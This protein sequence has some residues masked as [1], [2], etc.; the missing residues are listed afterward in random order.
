MKKRGVSESHARGV[1]ILTIILL[2]IQ[3]LIFEAT[4]IFKK[5]Q[6]ES[7]SNAEKIAIKSI[8][9]ESDFDPNILDLEGYKKLGFS[10]AQSKS[11]LKYREKIGG[12]KS[13]SDFK[14]LYVVSPQKY[15]QLESRIKIESKIAVKP[16]KLVSQKRD[17]AKSRVV[18][19]SVSIYKKESSPIFKKN[20]T[21]D[22][23]D[24]D[25]S[26]LVLLPGIG[27][28]F[29]RK[30]ISYRERLGGFATISQLEEIEGIDAERYK[31][32]EHKVETDTSK[33][34]KIDLTTVD[35]KLLGRHPYIGLYTARAIIN[36][37]N[38]FGAGM[39][40]LQNLIEGKLLKIEY[41][42]LLRYY[43]IPL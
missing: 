3:L 14:K 35:E 5:G 25:S 22:L 20:Y 37:R 23:N 29:A 34:R 38:K 8:I 41:A 32:F 12:F 39:C 28:Y 36:F 24:A 27:P 1:V 26:Q 18:N 15:T 10:E 16:T 11:I 2:S 43:F 19:D 40:T 7:Q 31:L 9:K 13:L 33:I 21:L 6:E 30:I 42:N 4:L 17:S